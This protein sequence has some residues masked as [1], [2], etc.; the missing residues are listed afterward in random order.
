MSLLAN[1]GL[2]SYFWLSMA[3]VTGAGIA[4]SKIHTFPMRVPNR[5][6]GQKTR[7]N[8]KG[9]INKRIIQYQIE[10]ESLTSRNEISE[11]VAPITIMI[12]T[13]LHW[14]MEAIVEV[15]R[16]GN[17]KFCFSRSKKNKQRPGAKKKGWG[18][19]FFPMAFKWDQS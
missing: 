6:N 5:F 8:T 13:V 9:M 11:S 17:L 10:M 15:S 2:V 18:R 12:R 1:K 7:V 14:P 4:N 16:V 19:I 3:I